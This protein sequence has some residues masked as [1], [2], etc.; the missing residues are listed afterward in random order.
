MLYLP[1]DYKYLHGAG[2]Y[3]TKGRKSIAMFDRF[4]CQGPKPKALRREQGKGVGQ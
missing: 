1:R 3:S 2:M 4:A